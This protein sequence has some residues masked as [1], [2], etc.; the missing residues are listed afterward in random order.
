MLVFDGMK[1]LLYVWDTSA[2]VGAEVTPDPFE[3]FQRALVVV[4]SGPEGL[5]QWHRER[6]DVYADYRRIFEEE[7]GPIKLVGLESHSNDTRTS[8]SVLFGTV[9]FEAR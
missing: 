5:G 8:T 6:R 7:P 9:R 4:R 1:G 2:P 3:I